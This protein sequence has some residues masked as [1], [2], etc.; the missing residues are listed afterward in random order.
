MVG[1]LVCWI[2]GWMIQN[3][4]PYHFILD[5]FF[6]FVPSFHFIFLCVYICIYIRGIL[7]NRCSWGRSDKKKKFNFHWISVLLDELS[8]I[9]LISIPLAHHFEC[10]TL[11]KFLLISETDTKHRNSN[12]NRKCISPS[13]SSSSSEQH[14]LRWRMF[15]RGMCSWMRL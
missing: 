10:R 2:D 4:A 11:I 15:A 7:L 6:Q 3:D 13:P 8:L 1:W 5:V 12:R 9:P 14:W